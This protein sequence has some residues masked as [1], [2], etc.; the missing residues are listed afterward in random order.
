NAVRDEQTPG[1]VQVFV[2]VLNFGSKQARTRVE[3]EVRGKN[4]AEYKRYVK[5]DEADVE[6]SPEKFPD[7]QPVLTLPP[8][9][10]KKGNPETGEPAADRPGRGDPV[11][12]ELTDINDSEN[13]VLRASL[14]GNKDAFKLD[15]QAWLVIGVV[16]KARV[17]I[18]T[19]GNNLLST[20]FDQEATAKVAAGPDLKPDQLDDD[21]QQEPA[22]R[23]RR[24]P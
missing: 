5:P 2:Q 13:V 10:Y 24:D 21:A 20:F 11:T 18:V 16:R 6:K 7:R 8:R 15:D 14:L 9:E 23:R 1:K 4:S 22:R 3:L 19:P 17:C 12:F